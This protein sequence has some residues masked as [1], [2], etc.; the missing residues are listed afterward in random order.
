MSGDHEKEDFADG[1]FEEIIPS[2]A[3]SWRLFLASNGSHRLTGGTVT[4]D[5]SYQAI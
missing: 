3:V 2:S 5:G 1:M 4:V